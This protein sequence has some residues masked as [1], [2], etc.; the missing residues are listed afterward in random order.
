MLNDDYN[1]FVQQLSV[2]KALVCLETQSARV[3]GTSCHQ[4]LILAE[5]CHDL[6]AFVHLEGR[7]STI[8]QHV[9]IHVLRCSRLCLRSHEKHNNGYVNNLFHELHL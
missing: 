1:H 6:G 9:R 2:R 7:V 8:Q 4:C 5:R 3:L